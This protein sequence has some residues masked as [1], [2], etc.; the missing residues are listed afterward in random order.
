MGRKPVHGMSGSR[1]HRIWMGVR[2]RCSVQYGSSSYLIKGIKVCER[3]NS[4][5]CFIEDM[6]PI[7]SPA[8]QIDR[9]D[10]NG[11]YEPTNCRWATLAEQ[12]RN[13]SSSVF[14]SFNGETLTQTEWAARI[15]VTAQAIRHRIGTLGWSTERAL[16]EGKKDING[17][18][19]PRSNA[20]TL[21]V[22]GTTLIVSEW[23]RRIGVRPGVL[24]HRIKMRWPKD[25]I[26]ERPKRGRKVVPE[27]KFSGVWRIATDPKHRS[28]KLCPKHPETH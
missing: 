11:N 26:L 22:D 23:A 8:H 5:E 9:I 18:P 4:F 2:R 19:H 13:R 1:E 12:Q 3:W 24:Y 10:S 28:Q 20:V 21:E 15:G 25:R 14:L 27:G 7:P 16:T 6:G 17:G